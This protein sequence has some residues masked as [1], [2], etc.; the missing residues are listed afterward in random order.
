MFLQIYHHNMFSYTPVQL[1]SQSGRHCRKFKTD[2]AILG[3]NWFQDYAQISQTNCDE[4]TNNQILLVLT[5]PLQFNFNHK[6]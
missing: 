4:D 2:K 5:N 6:K 3:K 1:L